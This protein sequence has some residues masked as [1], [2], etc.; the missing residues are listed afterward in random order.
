MLT[1]HE[2]ELIGDIDRKAPTPERTWG[3]GE[4]RGGEGKA[5]ELPD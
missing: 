3:R 2:I 1:V 5:C 4:E